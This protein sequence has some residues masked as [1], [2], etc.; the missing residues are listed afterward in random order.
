MEKKAK[1]LIVEDSID[2]SDLIS[3]HLEEEYSVLRAYNGL[4]AIQIFDQQ[5]IDIVLLDLMLPNKNGYE[6]MKHIRERSNVPIIIV[7]AKG[8]DAEKVIGLNKGADDYIAKPFNPLELTARVSA[9]LRRYL[10]LGSSDK[11]EDQ[12]ITV[13]GIVLDCNE[14]CLYKDNKKIIL[15][16]KEYNLIKLLMGAPG[17]IFTPKEIYENIWEEEYLYDN[18][19]VM[20]YISK[21]RDYI[22]DDSKKPKYI[23]NVRGLGYKFE[24]E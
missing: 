17:R 7:S 21:V 8:E 10:L 16:N 1:V 2:I 3:L 14:C 23:I 19:S 18:N 5:N 6:V 20:V 11:N 13:R 4:E 24:K 12:N 9:Q 15:S 22:E